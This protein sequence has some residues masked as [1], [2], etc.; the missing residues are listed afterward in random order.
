MEEEDVPVLAEG[1]VCLV[2]VVCGVQSG[3]EDGFCGSQWQEW[4]QESV[5]QPV[6]DL[7]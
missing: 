3:L 1:F 7:Q 2:P 4:L 6:V 5:V